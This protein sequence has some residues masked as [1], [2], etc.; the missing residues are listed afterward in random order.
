MIALCS[1]YTVDFI[2]SDFSAVACICKL[3]YADA[4]RLFY[5]NL[6]LV[7]FYKIK[8]LFYIIA[9]MIYQSKVLTYCGGSIYHV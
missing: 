4:S 3:L 6:N 9:G 5:F 7:F 8:K 2:N 1:D